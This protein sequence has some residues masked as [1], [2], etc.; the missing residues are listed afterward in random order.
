MC[1]PPS[2]F[3]SQFPVVLCGLT[4][5]S[6]LV[7]CGRVQ[8]RKAWPWCLNCPEASG[9][10]STERSVHVSRARANASSRTN[11]NFQNRLM[12]KHEFQVRVAQNFLVACAYPSVAF[13]FR[14]CW[15]YIVRLQKARSLSAQGHALGPQDQKYTFETLTRTE[16]SKWVWVIS[17]GVIFP[18]RLFETQENAIS[19]LIFQHRI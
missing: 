15:N 9:L 2:P 12:H 4:R 14:I 5:R 18:I 16:R 17:L 13:V 11:C 7:Q 1:N 6:C 19:N 10:V 8:L 3:R